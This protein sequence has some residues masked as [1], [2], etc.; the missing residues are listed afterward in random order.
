M[1]YAKMEFLPS[2]VSAPTCALPADWG[3]DSRLDPPTE[4]A[5]AGVLPQLGRRR[6]AA[7]LDGS[8]PPGW[9][10]A[11]DAPPGGVVCGTGPVHVSG[12]SRYGISE[13]QH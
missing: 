9:Q 6:P 8:N 4:L 1:T 5:P 12:G 13:Y 2:K 7:P 11:P 3:S 10:L